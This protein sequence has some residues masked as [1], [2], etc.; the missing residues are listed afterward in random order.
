[1]ADHAAG[2][3]AEGSEARV[4][5]GADAREAAAALE[6]GR[7]L[8][9][10]ECGFV[11]AAVSLDSLPLARLPEVA[12]AGRSNVGKSSLINALTGQAKLARASRTPG[13]TQQIN[14]FELGGRLQL[15]DLP[16]YGYAVAAKERISEWTTLVEDYVKGRPTLRRVSLLIDAR[17]GLKDADRR[18]MTLLDQAA[19]SYMLVLTKSDTLKPAALEAAEA[20]LAAEA[21]SHPAAH[22]LVLAT[23][24]LTGQGIERLRGELAA[25]AA[26]E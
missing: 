8:F 19:V 10:R 7:L 12:F 6:R 3:E 20:A 13:R 9:A 22:P 2:E 5:E 24:T 25:I 4:S 1:M 17:H 11:W 14:F 18:I 16:G 15:V 23:S 26:P 21:A